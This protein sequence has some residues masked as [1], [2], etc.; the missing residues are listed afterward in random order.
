MAS[1]RS[2]IPEG[3]S[4]RDNDANPDGSSHAKSLSVPKRTSRPFRYEEVRALE[5]NNDYVISTWN[6]LMFLAWR[7]RETANGITRSRILMA[8]WAEAK[9]NVVLVI[10][11]PP[12]AALA[13]PPSDDARGAMA[14]VSRNAAAALKGIGIIGNVSGFIGSVV[15]SVMTARQALARTPVPFKMFSS[16]EEAAPWIS[17]RLELRDSMGAEFVSAVEKAHWK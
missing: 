1:T 10:L 9:N 2:V 16:P 15:R 4:Q 8:P 12:R 14:D 6:D 13:Q 3:T 11:M 17:Q 7:G 5:R